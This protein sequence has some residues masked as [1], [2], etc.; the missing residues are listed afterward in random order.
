MQWDNKQGCQSGMRVAIPSAPTNPLPLL[1]PGTGGPSSGLIRLFIRAALPPLCC[2]FTATV[3]APGSAWRISRSSL[4]ALA[5]KDPATLNVLQQ[6][7][8]R[9]TCLSAAHALEVLDRVAHS[10]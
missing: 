1:G 2:S 6:L 7:V 9:S 4:E 5:A 3:E 10:I 8:L